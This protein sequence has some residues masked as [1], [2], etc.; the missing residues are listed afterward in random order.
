MKK[1]LSKFI[2]NAVDKAFIEFDSS[3]HDYM[4]RFDNIEELIDDFSKYVWYKARL[5]GIKIKDIKEY[6]KKGGIVKITSLSLDKNRPNSISKIH[7]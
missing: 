4:K 1:D 7:Y 2:K 5:H 6:L 3:F